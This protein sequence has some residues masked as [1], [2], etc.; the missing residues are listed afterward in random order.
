MPAKRQLADMHRGQLDRSR[1]YVGDLDGESDIYQTCIG[2]VAVSTVADVDKSGPNE[3]SAAIVPVNGDGLVLMVADGVGGLPAAKRASNLAVQTIGDQVSNAEDGASRLRTAILDGIEAANQALLELGTG[4]ATTLAL[5]EIRQNYIRSYHVGDSSIWLCGQRGRIK[6]QTTPH[7]PI[8]FAVESGLLDESDALLHEELNVI[9]NAIGTT[10]MR[11]EI[12]SELPF[13][14][15][16]TLLIAS[17][18]L[19]DNLLET[20][21]I[22]TIRKGPLST[23]IQSLTELAAARMREQHDDAPSKPDDFTAVLFRPDGT[24][25]STSARST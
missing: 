6:L 15:R 4:S 24:A 8:G 3:D 1:L 7:S 11:I 10:D 14:A 5:A 18:G 20:E 16:D 19:F 17:D 12:S 13:A 22:D 9:S 2:Q 25:T 23:V 21:I